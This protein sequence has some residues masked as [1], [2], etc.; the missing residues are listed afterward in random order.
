MLIFQEIPGSYQICGRGHIASAAISVISLTKFFAHLPAT[1]A[2]WHSGEG[3]N[4]ARFLLC[5]HLITGKSRHDQE[6]HCCY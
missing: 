2:C 4:Q 6:K 1:N 3:D 5:D